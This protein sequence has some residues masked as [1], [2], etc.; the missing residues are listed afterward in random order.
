MIIKYFNDNILNYLFCTTTII[1]GVN[2][3]A[4]NVI[5]FDYCN[6]KGRAGRM[7]IHLIGK[8]YNFNQPPKKEQI[9]I[10]IPFFEQNPISDE[11]MINLYPSEVRYP[12]SKQNK[13]IGNIPDDLKNVIKHNSVIV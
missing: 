2:T 8:I 3:T 7:M 12:N 1:E 10:D 4:K 6:I 11:V 13:Y 5:Y 9:I